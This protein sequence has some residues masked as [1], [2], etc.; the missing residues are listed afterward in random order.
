MRAPAERRRTA[1]DG[2]SLRED[3]NARESLTARDGRILRED[4]NAREGWS[5]AAKFHTPIG[6]NVQ[7]AR[8]RIVDAAC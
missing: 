8:M 6:E 7:Q 3:R 5:T 2:R 1:R 4:R